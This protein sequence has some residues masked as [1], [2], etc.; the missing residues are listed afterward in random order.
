MMNRR[1]FLKTAILGTC[2]LSVPVWAKPQVWIPDPSMGL[3]PVKI[4][5]YVFRF[6]RKGD[7]DHHCEGSEWGFASS[8]EAKRKFDIF[9][10][11]FPLEEYELTK[12]EIT[13][14]N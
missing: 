8:E 11:S 9:A 7:N 3:Q 14:V 10:K 5:K 12:F 2:A 1:N 13:N 6:D 4:W